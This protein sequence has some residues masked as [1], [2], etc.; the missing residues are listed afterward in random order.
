MDSSLSGERVQAS[1]APHG[2]VTFLFT[3][4][5]GS[6]RLLEQF[7]EQYARILEEQRQILRG[8]F[9][10]WHGQ[11]VDTQGDAFFVVFDR[12]TEAIN[13]AIDAQHSLAEHAW[14]E[15]VRVRVRMGL[16]TGLPVRTPGGYIGMDVHRAARI[17]AAGHGGQVLLS[18]DTRRLVEAG[19]P[20]GTRLKDLGKHLLK[21]IPNPEWIYQAVIPGLPCDFPPLKTQEILANNL[22]QQLTSFIGREQ[23]IED[24]RQRLVGERLVTLVG[25]GGCGKTRLAL[26]AAGGMAGEFPNGIRL[27]ELAPLSDPATVAHTVVKTLNLIEQG[28]RSPLEILVDFLRPKRLLLV[29]DNCEHLIEACARLV[30]TLLRSCPEIRV[31]ATSREALGVAGEGVFYVPSLSTPRANGPLTGE[32]AGQYEAV[33]LFQERAASCL[34]GFRVTDDNAAT[35]VQICRRLDGIPLAIELAAARVRMLTVE[36][37]AA[38]LDDCFHLL[39]GG[40]RTSLPRHQT[41]RAT[42]DWSYALL[43]EPERILLRRLSVFSGGWTLEAAEAVCAGGGLKKA[44]ILDLLAGLASKSMVQTLPA[45]SGTVRYRMLETIQQYGEE[46]LRQADEETGRRQQHLEHFLRFAETGG[47]KLRGPESLEWLHR[48]EEEYANLRAALEWCFGAGQAGEAGVW[49]TNSLVEF[50][51]GSSYYHEWLTWLEKALEQS[52]SLIGTP[53]RAKILYWYGSFMIG[54]VGKWEV[55]RPLLEESLEAWRLLGAAYRTDYADVLLWLGYHLYNRG[56][57]HQGCLYLQEGTDIS[58]EAGDSWGLGCALILFSVVKFQDGDVETAFVMAH[59]GADA[60]RKSGDRSGVANCLQNLGVFRLKQGKYLEALPYLEE[61]LG[62]FREYGRKVYACQSL[63]A[64]GEVARALKEY[65]KAE[66]CYRESLSMRQEIGA[67]PSWLIAPNLNLGYTVLY[68]GDEHQAVS[69]FT[70]AL[71]LS[72]DVDK[73]G[74]VVASLA[75]LAA[76]AAARGKVEAAARLYGAAEAQYQGPLAEG[77]TLDSMIDP[78]DRREFE[79]YQAM[80]RNQL[81]EA[82]FDAAWAEGQGMTLEQA[83]DEALAVS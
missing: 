55:A 83:L 47:R 70:Q 50:W 60:F 26:Q 51:N 16:H 49:L 76:V 77:K 44:E 2:T 1:D 64:L 75:G 37:I 48:M 23:E 24:V 59:E 45:S 52:R 74:W 15:G 20:E 11:E 40:S 58:R 7:P 65:E 80:C 82:T 81:G 25:A 17:A 57:S 32:K 56:Q 19:L 3:D 61:A 5:E 13:C 27:V 12:A 39:T 10:R 62:I 8:A 42:I 41:L 73:G 33:R 4:I 46:K 53:A 21:D 36:Q 78:V 38:R 72:R 54:E 43:S 79:H 28:E 35:V 9:A 67:G 29:M 31:L 68:R 14:P 66:A 6:T 69:F 63:L 34:V 18:E 22:P 30:E 71:D